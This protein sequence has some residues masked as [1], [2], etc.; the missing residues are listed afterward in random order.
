M[1]LTVFDIMTKRLEFVTEMASVQEA[2]RKMK[3]ECELVDSNGL[4]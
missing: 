1:T 3:V 4:E 2:A